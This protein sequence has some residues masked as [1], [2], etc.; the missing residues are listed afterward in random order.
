MIPWKT[1]R[2]HFSFLT[3]AFFSILLVGLV[4]V[5]TL[6]R[7]N[8][9]TR[10][11]AY[12]RT[13]LVV[14]GDT[15][16]AQA[17]T[18]TSTSS[19]IE[20]GTPPPNCHYTE[21]QCFQA[22]CPQILECDSPA[23]TPQQGACTADY[24]PVCGANNV[25]YSNSCYAKLSGVPVQYSGACKT[26]TSS[27]KQTPPPGCYYQTVQCFQ[28]PCPTMLVCPSPAVTPKPTPAP[29]C[30]AACSS[31]DQCGSGQV[32]YQ[33]PMPS[34][35]PGMACIQVMPTKVCRNVSCI[36]STTC[37]CGPSTP[38]PVSPFPTGT[39]A[40]VADLLGDVDGNGKVDIF[41][42]NAL[43]MLFGQSGANLNADFDNNLKVDIFDFNILLSNF[44]KQR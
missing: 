16:V 25:T 19:F 29:A 20:K 3:I 35:P 37:S 31:T 40:P 17:E 30:N 6:V 7:T 34:C 12:D 5:F 41:D 1:P 43:L 8:Q 33:P 32:C 9:D 36:T 2:R 15:D 27:P 42:F 24:D 21:V 11:L 18:T 10:Q 4:A 28:A 14:L 26:T 44:G 23:P 22:P 39:P 38:P 13:D